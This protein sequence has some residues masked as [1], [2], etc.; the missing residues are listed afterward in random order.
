MEQLATQIAVAV[1]SARTH[2][3]ARTYQEQLAEEHER[4]RLVHDITNTLV[5]HIDAKELFAEI[6][7][8]IGRIM[9]HDYCSLCVYEPSNNQFRLRALD[10]PKGKE[11]LREET[12]FPAED[13]PVGRVLATHT[14]LLISRLS[15]Q[16]FPSKG[17]QLLLDS[18]IKS[19]C[20]LPLTGRK[21]F[22]G[23]LSVCSFRESAFSQGDLHLLSEV[24]NQVAI[25]VDN[26]L[27][28]QEIAELKDKLAEEK[29]YLEDEIRTEHNFEE[30][31]GESA[32]LKHTSGPKAGPHLETFLIAFFNCSLVFST[33]CSSLSMDRRI[34]LLA[35]FSESRLSST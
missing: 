19:G 7:K 18:G 25:A 6:S 14:P 23:T 29:V 33:F 20:W 2:D 22:L 30:I 34:F 1:D 8:C 9:H 27:A 32:A 17:T 4:L 24:A 31:V 26:A 3:T 5:S 28:F 21:R 13:S 12:V 11:L 35:T 10:F 15:I 16:T